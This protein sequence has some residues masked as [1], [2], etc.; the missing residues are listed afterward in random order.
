MAI[1]IEQ[2]P[3][4]NYF[5]AGQPLVWAVKESA[6]GTYFNFKYIVEVYITSSNT[7]NLST[8][9][10]K[11]AIFKTTPNNEGVG[12]FDLG[13]FLE[14]YVSSQNQ[15]VGGPGQSSSQY[16]GVDYGLD[17]PHPIHLIDEFCKGNNVIRGMAVKFKAE[18]ATTQNGAVSD[19]GVV[20]NG[21][22][23]WYFNGVLQHDNVLTLGQTGANQGNYGYNFTANDLYTTE[24]GGGFLTN[25]PTT[26]Y[27]NIDDYGTVGFLNFAPNGS[28]DKVTKIK[29]TYYKTDGSTVTENITQGFG[30]GGCTNLDSTRCKF[31]FA[32]VYPANLRNHSST[33][34]GL[35]SANTIDYYTFQAESSN[36]GATTNSKLY[37][38]NINCPNTKGYESIR[39]TWLNQWGA[40]DYYTFTQKS[41]KSLTTN[42]TTYTQMSGSWNEAKYRIY[43]YKGGRKNFRVNTTER[44]VVNTDY[45]AEENSA[46]FED[47]INSTEV[48]ILNGFDAA[49]SNP[50]N[51]ITNKYVEPVL[52]TTSDFTRKTVANDK[53]IQY[54]FSM[55]RNKTKNTQS[56]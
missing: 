2:R 43:G 39:L 10:D 21:S 26:Q 1:T 53:L 17:T 30:T 19:L 55:E 7:I 12:I 42:R 24:D 41:T 37:T 25:A 8:S 29:F 54:T 40:W 23:N 50:Y 3:L 13:P 32:G 51:T 16:K 4:Y 45:I 27:A 56:V 9:T 14:S 49:E 18:G 44:I 38:I 47:L 36:S 35:V 5:V 33:F 46:W 22:M 34:Q 28:S 6:V 15:G 52:I 11:R 48:Y 31:I 20:K